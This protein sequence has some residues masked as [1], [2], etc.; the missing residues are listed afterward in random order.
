MNKQD[1][2]ATIVKETGATK[3]QTSRIVSVLLTAVTKALKKG[4]PVT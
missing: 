1:L 2:I 4:E 3:A